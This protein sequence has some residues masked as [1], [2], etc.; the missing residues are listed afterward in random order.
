MIKSIIVIFNDSLVTSM[1]DGRAFFFIIFVDFV[2]ISNFVTE[3]LSYCPFYM[4]IFNYLVLSYA[5][6]IL[7]AN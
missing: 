2:I 4:A 7:L 6:F 1:N 3:N 5:Y